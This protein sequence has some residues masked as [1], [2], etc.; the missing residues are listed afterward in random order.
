MVCKRSRSAEDQ[1]H[2]E[3]FKRLDARLNSDTPN[4]RSQVPNRTF[5]CGADPQD[6]VFLS[7]DT[8]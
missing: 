8:R 2:R 7:L 1:K 6:S 5:G 4:I 3:A